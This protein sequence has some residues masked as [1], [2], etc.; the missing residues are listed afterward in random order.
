MAVSTVDLVKQGMA[1]GKNS[2]QMVEE[3]LLKD[4]EKWSAP[5]ITSE[6]WIAQVYESLFGGLKTSISMP[7]I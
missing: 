2:Q 6:N 3:N 1:A 5:Q 4:W 7:L